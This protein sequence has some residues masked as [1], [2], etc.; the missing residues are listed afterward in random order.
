MKRTS[1]PWLSGILL[2]GA[3][4][5]VLVFG[6][7]TDKLI[8]PGRGIGPAALGISP[9]QAMSA[10]GK[11]SAKYHVTDGYLY[12][13]GDLDLFTSEDGRVIRVETDS[14]DYRTREGL[15]VGS[16]ETEITAKLGKPALAEDVKARN[17]NILMT[18]GRRLCYE[19]G[20]V[21][22]AEYL[23]MQPHATTRVAVRGDGCARAFGK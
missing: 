17:D 10:L 23:P 14:A 22:S 6:A 3:L 13:F 19:P 11:P 18:T 9:E 15:G 8:V 2:A 4:A 16:K 7:A 5:P 12:S 1:L 20:L 21:F